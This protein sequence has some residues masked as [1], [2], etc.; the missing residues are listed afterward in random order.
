MNIKFNKKEKI[1]LVVYLFT[2]LILGVGITYSFFLLADRAKKDSTKVYAGKLDVNYI[3]GS[4]VVA[5]VL[6]PI[7]EPNFN[8]EKDVYKNRFIVSSEG[9][10]EQ[11]VSINFQVSRNEFSDNAIK[12]ALYDSNGTKLS[13]GYINKGMV[14]LIDNLYFKEI[15]SRDYILIIWLQETPEN[16][17][18]EQG[19]K[20]AGRIVIQS[21]QYGY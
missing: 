3:E 4:L 7:P 16:Q 6:Y 18:S 15:E 17:S 13:T 12:Y 1:I 19:N 11:N 20:L 5:D 14:T 10:L 9:T 2:I 8:V 21:K